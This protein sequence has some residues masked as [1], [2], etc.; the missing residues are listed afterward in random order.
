MTTIFD[1]RMRL[2]FGQIYLMTGGVGWPDF[3]DSRR[4]QVNGLLGAAQ[5]GR[6]LLTTGLHTGEVGLRVERLDAEPALD[7][8]WEEIVEVSF[9]PAGTAL[10]LHGLDSSQV[11]K[12]ELPVVSY[13]ARY[14]AA[15][16]DKGKE[17]DVVSADEPV[18]DRYLLQLWPA[19]PA[20]DV[21]RKQTSATASY[22]HQEH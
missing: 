3:D 12:T 1:G 11:V 13:R 20:P 15:D 8:Q 16:M 9:A 4:G 22:W 21:I 7:D 17:V 5:S 14:C 10:L 19:G 18:V 6:L 2:S